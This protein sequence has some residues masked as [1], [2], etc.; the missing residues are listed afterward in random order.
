MNIVKRN[1]VSNS[2]TERQ[3]FP[4]LPLNI[5]KDNSSPYTTILFRNQMDCY[6]VMLYKSC[7]A[8]TQR[9]HA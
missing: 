6:P 5:G 1:D 8:K 2:S 3:I 7:N 9:H 4:I